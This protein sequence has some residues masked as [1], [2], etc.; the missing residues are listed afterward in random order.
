MDQDADC[1]QGQDGG[2]QD[3]EDAE[4]AGA[5]VDAQPGQHQDEC[6][7]HDRDHRPGHRQAEDVGQSLWACTARARTPICRA[8]YDTSA[9]SAAASPHPRPRL[10]AM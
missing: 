5:H 2:L 3:Q 10:V 4:H 6:H 1:H 7:G 9:S 8:L